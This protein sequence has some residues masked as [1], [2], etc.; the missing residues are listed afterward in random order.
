MTR[1]GF[2][3]RWIMGTAQP[4]LFYVLWKN[5]KKTGTVTVTLLTHIFSS[6]DG[7]IGEWYYPMCDKTQPSKNCGYYIC[8]R[9]IGRNIFGYAIYIY[10]PIINLN[11]AKD[12]EDIYMFYDDQTISLPE[13]TYYYKEM[14]SAKGDI[15]YY[16]LKK[17]EVKANENT[18]LIIDHEPNL[19]KCYTEFEIKPEEWHIDNAGIYE[20]VFLPHWGMNSVADN[21]IHHPVINNKI[22]VNIRKLTWQDIHYE[23]RII[24]NDIPIEQFVYD[25]EGAYVWCD[26]GQYVDRE[27]L[28]KRP[29][30][31]TSTPDV[32]LDGDIVLMQEYFA[33]FYERYRGT[34]SP[35]ISLSYSPING[36]F[37]AENYAMDYWEY[38]IQEPYY[39]IDEIKTD[40]VPDTKKEID[41]Y[42]NGSV[43]NVSWTFP[44]Y[45][46]LWTQHIRKRPSSGAEIEE[47]YDEDFSYTNKEIVLLAHCVPK[48]VAPFPYWMC[49]RITDYR[50]VGGGAGMPCYYGIS[51]WEYDARDAEG[52]LIYND[53]GTIK[54]Y[55]YTELYGYGD[56]VNGEVGRLPYDK[57]YEIKRAGEET[58]LYTFP[59]E[60]EKCNDIYTCTVIYQEQTRKQYMVLHDIPDRPELVI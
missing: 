19:L 43:M 8:T 55:Y 14:I 26:G 59:E 51:C 46:V 16:E 58:Y 49:R 22:G 56:A 57:L 9:R 12:A 20:D 23:N 30:E 15:L 60:R 27:H 37:Q 21:T 35:Y 17:F 25:F 39:E 47:E 1:K 42:F 38:K 7:L 13:G 54:Q 53:D 11:A 4:E 31:K 50:P 33:T 6:I 2:R 5:R 24:Y 10:D 45:D 34:T 52:N 3:K 44:E 29:P 41:T 48:D 40:I 32:T 36:S 28:Q 18:E